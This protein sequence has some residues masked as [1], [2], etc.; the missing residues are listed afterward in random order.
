M[1]D[2]TSLVAISWWQSE[3]EVVD[4]TIE[5]DISLEKLKKKGI[6]HDVSDDVG[7][8]D[9]GAIIRKCDFPEYYLPAND[10]YYDVT[11]KWF[12]KLPKQTE[13]IFAHFAEYGD[14][15]TLPL[16]GIK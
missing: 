12:E 8:I 7:Y 2:R 10:P 1:G 15:L 11:K 9:A 3:Y 14:N 16:M 5:G 4:Q 6:V 13:F